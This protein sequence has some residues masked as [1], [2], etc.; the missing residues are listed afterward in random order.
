M[1]VSHTR[2][3]RMMTLRRDSFRPLLSYDPG[4]VPIEK[5]RAGPVPEVSRPV[6]FPLP[7]QKP[8]LPQVID[9]L[10][11]QLLFGIAAARAG[12]ALMTDQHSLEQPHMKAYAGKKC[13]LALAHGTRH[14][15]S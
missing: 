9:A 14:S 15:W 2:P 5:C 13:M 11:V 3:S 7:S 10:N 8:M 4:G 6:Y 1:C 12:A